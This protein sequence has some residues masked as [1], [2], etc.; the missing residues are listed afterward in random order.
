M[1]DPTFPASD[2]VPR[3]NEQQCDDIGD[4]CPGRP[5]S[6]LASASCPIRSGPTHTDQ[7]LCIAESARDGQSFVGNLV[8]TSGGPERVPKHLALGGIEI[9]D[10]DP[11]DHQND[12]RPQL[13]VGAVRPCPNESGGEV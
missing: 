3:I 7:E 11:V 10:V 12:A 9:V 1:S 5:G 2:S 4:H 6:T 13:E 8:A